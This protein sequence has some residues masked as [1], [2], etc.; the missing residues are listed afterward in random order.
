MWELK[1]RAQTKNR[2]PE[3]I[4]IDWWTLLTL[5][6]W[7]HSNSHHHYLPVW[8]CM[9]WQQTRENTKGQFFNCLPL[10]R[11]WQPAIC[12]FP[13]AQ[14]AELGL[15]FHLSE[16]QMS[17]AEDKWFHY[18]YQSVS[19]H[20]TWRYKRNASC[21]LSSWSGRSLEILAVCWP[22]RH[23]EHIWLWG[24]LQFLVN[25]VKSRLLAAPAIPVPPASET[26]NYQ[27]QEATINEITLSHLEL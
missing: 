17:T 19:S 24:L 20:T 5:N 2:S 26:S 23:G 22:Q 16:I 25:Y 21:C 15:H 8:I 4:L 9:L 14:Q 3:H 7:R 1:V 18:Q 11:S 27:E 13:S 10:Y 12:H 6:G